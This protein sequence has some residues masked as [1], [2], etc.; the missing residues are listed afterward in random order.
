MLIEWFGTWIAGKAFGFLVKTIISQEF[1]QELVKD[2]AKDFFRNIIHTAVTAPFQREPLQKAEVMAFA[3][4]L[5]LMQQ[6]LEDSLLSQEEIENYSQPLQQF[7]KQSEV[8][9]IL[10]AAF[11][12]EC[13][14]I[15]TKRL[16]EIWY[17]L[18]ASSSLPEDFKWKKIGKEYLQ[19]VKNIIREFPELRA[20]LDSQNIEQIKEYTKAQAGII[21]AFDLERYQEGIK[22]R[23]GNLK[24]ESLDTTGY[25]YNELKLWRMFIAQN[26]REVHQVLPRVHELPKEHFRRL[27]ETDQIEAEIAAEELQQLTRV[28][29]EQ[30]LLSVLDVVNNQQTY[31]YIVVLGDPGS[32]KSTLLQYLALNWADSPLDNVISQPIPLLIELRTYMRR[33]DDKECDSFLEF[34]DKCSGTIE[35]LNQHQLHEQ[36]QAGNALVMFDGLDE[37]FEAGKR[38][39]VI[40][41]IHRFTNEY[42]NV[43]V[44]VTSRVIGYKP[45]RLRDAEFRHFMLQDLDAE[46]IQDFIYR[47]HELTFSDEADKLRKRERLERGIKNSKAITELAGNPLLLTMMAILNRNQELPRDRS[48]LYEQASRVLL[49]QWDVER[50]L[51]E[52]KRLDHKTIDYKDKQAMLRQ[53]AYKMQTSGAGLAGNVISSSE[54]EKI[55]AEY[56][57][58]IEI[59][60]PREAARVMI[61]QLRTRNFMLCFLGADYYA[62]VHRTFLEYFCAWEFVWQFKETQ[63]LNI[64]RLKE[65]VF[66]KHWD[67]ETWHEVLLL[68]AGMIEAK[69][70]GEIIE[71]LMVLDG[72][73][74][75][76]INI[77]LAANCL[78]EVR[79]HSV[80]ESTADKLLKRLKDLTEYDLWYCRH[81]DFDDEEAN[82]IQEIRSEAVTAIITIWQDDPN[83]KTFLEQLATAKDDWDV[84]WIV[85]E[86]LVQAYKDD[87]TTKTFLQQL[88][89]TDSNSGVR[90]TAVEQL[91]QT[92]KDDPTTKTILQQLATVDDDS[93]LPLTA[94]HQLVQAYKDDPKT[95][96]FLQQ[97]A[98][99]DNNLI[100]RQIAIREL[101][102]AYKDDPNTKT[103]LKKL[104][105]KDNNPY[106]RQTAVRELAQAYKDDPTTKTILQQRAIVDNN[107]NVRRTAVEQLA[108]VYKDD[109]TTKTI[110]QQRASGDNNSDVR[111]TAVEQLAQ[112][113]KDDP[114]TKTILQERATADDNSD[115]RRTA[116]KQ[117]VQA[118]KDDLTTKT[119]LQELVNTNDNSNVRGTAVEQLAQ[120]Y[121]D[122]PNIKSILL[123]LATADDNSGM[124]LT[125]VREL[126]QVDEDDA[127]IKIILQQ[128]A[129]EDNN[130]YVRWTAVQDLALTYEDDPTTKNILQQRATADDNWEVRRLAV[131]HLVQSYKD[132]P[133]T[134]TFLQQRATADDDSDMRWTAV[135][136]LAKA[137]KS[138]PEL[139]EIYY[140]CAINDPFDDS[141]DD[142]YA[143]PRRVAL[144]II[145]KQYPQHPQTLPLLRDRAENDPDEKVREYAREK[146][147]KLD[148]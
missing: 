60:Q 141:H 98:T 17:Q 30:P 3:E 57:R 64:E 39:D 33:R 36:L 121:K 72:E 84:Q 66:G 5:Q 80:I 76:F 102:Q 93:S 10:G 74:K 68:I 78:I 22:E 94:V 132:D 83:T 13:E 14:A 133:D 56:L 53:V 15:N 120:A 8:K 107:S 148:Q 41:D 9:E 105:I 43:Q 54:L 71:Y 47:W 69:F 44:I 88:A 59:Q 25:A 135:N 23:Y 137:Y 116:V 12:Y 143:N 109:P 122:D 42:P 144:E 147:A 97:L 24:L 145:V 139:F 131:E 48:S 52:D 32:G 38:E 11:Y 101:V 127:N 123:Q 4:F 113:Y 40:T 87:P 6:D 130:W 86:Y 73:E 28:Y 128:L 26:V 58:S 96:T 129:T 1:L 55:L 81:P 142:F 125:A 70:V 108:Q 16:K 85:V 92:Y 35:H 104:V 119:F 89:T 124:R 140:D 75:K 31:K 29:L 18:T 114:T 118:Y 7:L 20:I 34:L 134:K 111:Q 100:V 112:A 51:V 115:V 19:K 21:P 2:Y 82:L 90:W 61:N 50:A 65:E 138:Q 49:H 146:L 63:T 46:Q 95:K 110:L 67:D 106:V 91:A 79:N 27:R 126:A 117:L 37:V 99:A 77:F 62:F 103:I 45:Q 136:E